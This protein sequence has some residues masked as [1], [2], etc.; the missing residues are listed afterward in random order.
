MPDM[1]PTPT[2]TP[3][4][5]GSQSSQGNGSP[6]KRRR[7]DEENDDATRQSQM[8]WFEDGNIVLVAEG[9]AFKVHLGLLA[10]QCSVFKDMFGVVEQ[11]DNAER[12]FDAPVVRLHDSQQNLE[13]FLQVLY[14]GFQC[15]AYAQFHYII[16]H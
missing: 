6:S 13:A 7:T 2:P 14:D 12:M 15:V 1:P 9:L 8:V 5:S 16:T 10:R 11:P 4:K 3:A